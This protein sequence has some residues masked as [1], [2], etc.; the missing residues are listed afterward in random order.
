MNYLGFATWLS[1]GAAVFC[2]P[3]L[4]WKQ[5]DLPRPIK[6][7]LGF[8]IVYLLMT[9]VITLLPMLA[10]PVETGIGLA[11]ILTAVPVYLIFIQWQGKPSCLTSFTLL[12]T[13]QLQRLLVVMHLT[14]KSKNRFQKAG[15][16]KTGFR[17]LEQ[18][19]LGLE[20][21]TNKKWVQKA[22]TTK[23]GFRKLEP[24]KLV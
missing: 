22:E 7:N 24:Q 9:L 1:I 10:Q 23:T 11:M 21:W 20:S 2:L 3:Y 19:K 6:I 8:P 4:R 5:P 14:R 17:K 12:T 18:Q 13:D 15:T 16:T